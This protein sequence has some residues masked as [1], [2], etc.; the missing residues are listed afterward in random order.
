MRVSDY[1]VFDLVGGLIF[2]FTFGV[3]MCVGWRLGFAWVRFGGFGF[4]ASC[5]VWLF[6]LFTF[7]I[8]LVW[9]LFLCLID[10]DAG[11]G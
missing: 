10:C 1:V 11:V 8:A 5:L 7:E 3:L 6:G 4:V 2:R 9:L